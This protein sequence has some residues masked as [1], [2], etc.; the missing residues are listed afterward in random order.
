MIY[1]TV[2]AMFVGDDVSFG[3]SDFVIPMV[4]RK[5]LL[6]TRL[7]GGYGKTHNRLM[8]DEGV[9]KCWKVSRR[10]YFRKAC[11]ASKVMVAGYVQVVCS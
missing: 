9:W 7:E 11:I 5:G 10:L 2:G 6:Q 1:C 3:V 4:A 8:P